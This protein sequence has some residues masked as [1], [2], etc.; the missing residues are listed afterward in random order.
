MKGDSPEDY[1]F[2]NHK[3]MEL[4]LHRQLNGMSCLLLDFMSM[5]YD[6]TINYHTVFLF[7]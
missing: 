7:I 3:K 5:I 2:C 6:N 4:D 1:F